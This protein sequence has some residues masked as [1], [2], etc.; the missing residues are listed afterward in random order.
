MQWMKDSSLIEPQKNLSLALPQQSIF[1]LTQNTLSWIVSFVRAESLFV[2]LSLYHRY[3]WQCLSLSV[4]YM[5][6]TKSYVLF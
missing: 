2:L 1:W 6:L 5:Q 3:S 4:D